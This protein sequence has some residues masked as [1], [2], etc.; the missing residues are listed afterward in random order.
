MQIKELIYLRSKKTL[1]Q[2]VDE[3]FENHRNRKP[4]P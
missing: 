2:K 3:I 4:K 1:Q